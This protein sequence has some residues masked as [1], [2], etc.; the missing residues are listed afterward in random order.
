[1]I[2]LHTDDARSEAKFQ[3]RVKDFS[4]LKDTMLSPPCY[5]RNLPWKIMVMPR[6]S[7][8]QDRQPQRSLGFFLQCNGESESTS[9]SCNAVADLRLLSVRDGEPPFTRSKWN[10]G[11]VLRLYAL[12]CLEDSKTL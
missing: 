4:K 10:F 7:Q 8:S 3:F 5:V 1:M 12:L 11:A 2:V 6:T 9:W